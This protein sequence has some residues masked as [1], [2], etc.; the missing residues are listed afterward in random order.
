MRKPLLALALILALA[1]PLAAGSLAG[2]AL[3]DSTKVGDQSLVLNGMALRTKYSFKVYVA[4]LYLEARA[5][6]ATAILAADSQRRL[7]MHFLRSL[8]PE[9]ICE[10]WNDGLAANTPAASPEL[11][12]Q[13]AQLCSW[14]PAAETGTE[15]H[16]TYLPGSGTTVAIAG[17]AKGTIPGKAFADALLACWIGP[18]PGPGEEFKRALLGG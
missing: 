5:T 7:V 17:Q 13:F 11:K 4:G 10:G 14:M 2:V 3:S 18:K 6:D 15:I 1:A 9:K 8:D 16:F 12:Q